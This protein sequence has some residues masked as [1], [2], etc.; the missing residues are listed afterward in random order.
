[1]SHLSFALSKQYNLG[2]RLDRFK[3]N[4]IDLNDARESEEAWHALL[5]NTDAIFHLA[6]QT[7]HI[8]S[9]NDP[10]ADLAANCGVTLKLLEAC[11]EH[12]PEAAF[13]MPGT[14]TQAGRVKAVPAG[15]SLPDWPVSIY[16]AHK[17]TCEK[18][19]YVYAQNYGLKTTTLRLANVF[20]ER[21]QVNNPRRGIL[22]YMLKRA[23]TGDPIT[24]YEPGDFVRDCSYIQNVVDALLLAAAS[25]HTNGKSYVFGSG[26][27]LKFYEMI[28]Q[29]VEQVHAVTG[30]AAD[31][32]WVPFPSDEKRID[33]GDFIADN[34][35]FRAHTGWSERV[36]FAAGLRNTVEF[37]RD[38]LEHYT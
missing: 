14:V 17:L 9:M 18:Y 35:K 34:R 10:L 33:V 22:N 5:S 31:V 28:D 19:L 1:M 15:E 38:N 12:A 23:L 7:S 2:S 25:P 13:V 32:H 3:L 37:Y 11:R 30:L 20:G 8:E 6:A 24:I 16:D 4:T 29:L 21:Q 26:Q 27:G 36:D